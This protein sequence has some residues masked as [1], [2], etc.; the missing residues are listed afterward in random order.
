MVATATILPRVTLDSSGALPLAQVN[1]EPVAYSIVCD[2]D[3][4]TSTLIHNRLIRLMR[5]AVSIETPRKR[6]KM[7]RRAGGMPSV[8]CQQRSRGKCTARRHEPKTKEN[9]KN[10]GLIHG[11]RLCLFFE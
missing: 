2:F 4:R 5:G 11:I 10:P 8:F 7:T 1:H 3:V 6:H 9:I